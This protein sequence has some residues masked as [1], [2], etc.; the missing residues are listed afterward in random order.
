M[1]AGDRINSLQY[2]RSEVSS[3]SRDLL[4]QK[5]Y[6]ELSY[7]NVEADTLPTEEQVAI[8]TSV[9][10]GAT[11]DAE[12]E[13]SFKILIVIMYSFIEDYGDISAGLFDYIDVKL[14]E[15]ELSSKVRT[16]L[17]EGYFTVFL[18]INEGSHLLDLEAEFERWLDLLEDAYSKNQPDVVVAT[19]NGLGLLLSLITDS[20]ALNEQIE[21]LL[22]VL[23]PYL[24]DENIEISLAAGA[25]IAQ[26]FQDYTFV[27]DDDSNLPYFE[28]F[29]IVTTIKELVK[30]SSKA[31]SKDAKRNIHDL[32]RDVLETVEDNI[33]IDAK[34]DLETL[35]VLATFQ[36]LA[37]KDVPVTS[38]G[39]LQRLNHLKWAFG[40]GTR[41]LI[42]IS[43]TVTPLLT[44][45]T[46]QFREAKPNTL[47]GY[48]ID[49]RLPSRPSKK[50]S[51]I[52][53]SKAR[54]DKFGVLEI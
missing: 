51:D 10:K 31:I 25:L 28:K 6:Y 18:A 15:P 29:E 5:I 16:L 42:K 39:T 47:P 9:L 46:K 34:T 27:D 21:S 4:L 14:K 33:S 32:F 7:N 30:E 13:C 11:S 38:W 43:E 3:D 12:I 52:A 35:P 40:E 53:R 22:P 36:N 37:N 41:K 24:T 19:I 17:V 26:S 8:L 1:T 50:A 2:D 49:G 45:E 48:G 23:I 20:V 44:T 54:D